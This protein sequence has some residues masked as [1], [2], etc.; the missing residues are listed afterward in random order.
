MSG[1]IRNIIKEQKYCD[2]RILDMIKHYLNNVGWRDDERLNNIYWYIVNGRK[3]KEKKWKR[4][5]KKK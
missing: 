2:K 5:R 1:D 4:K 3:A